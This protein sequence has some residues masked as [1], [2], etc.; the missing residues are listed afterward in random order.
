MS[1]DESTRVLTR[2]ALSGAGI[3]Y[4]EEL[5]TPEALL[6]NCPQASVLGQFLL[7]FKHI[8][9]L[10]HLVSLGMYS[11]SRYLLNQEQKELDPQ[12]RG[13]VFEAER[14]HIVVP[15]KRPNT[16]AHYQTQLDYESHYNFTRCD[17]NF[18]LAME[19]KKLASSI[20][21]KDEDR[22]IEVVKCVFKRLTDVARNAECDD[23]PRTA[24]NVVGRY[25]V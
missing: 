24:A 25:R 4:D 19:I 14:A 9:T 8:I 2:D 10:E 5:I 21:S 16:Q 6:K 7:D 15:K 20:R 12:P 1:E 11:I 22:W 13:Q 3:Q 17:A 23:F 18:G